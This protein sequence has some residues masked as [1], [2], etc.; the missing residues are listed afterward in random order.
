M[1]AVCPVL[2]SRTRARGRGGPWGSAP[3]SSPSVPTGMISLPYA[4]IR[5]P[6]EA[7]YN[8]TGGKSRIEYYG[9]G[10]REGP[11]PHPSPSP[12]PLTVPLLLP[13][14][15]WVPQQSPGSHHSARTWGL[16]FDH[17]T[18]SRPS[19]HLPVWLHRALRCQLQGDPRDHRDRGQ[20]PQ[21][22]PHQRHQQ[23]PH[24]PA[25]RL[26]QPG[27]LQGELQTWSPGT[28]DGAGTRDT[29]WVQPV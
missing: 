20:C 28:W 16:G 23:G 14:D 10:C 4:E 9:G 21:V 8:L 3:L 5:E 17:S 12:G 18:V 6:F 19:G 11:N 29:P 27:E 15:L 25:E 13:Q 22:L 7:W 24:C 2:L 1:L 26:P